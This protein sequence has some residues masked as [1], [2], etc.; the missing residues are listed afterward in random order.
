MITNQTNKNIGFT[1]DLFDIL[2][3]Q[4]EWQKQTAV[5]ADNFFPTLKQKERKR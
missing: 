2:L 4:L 3:L 5:D 1:S